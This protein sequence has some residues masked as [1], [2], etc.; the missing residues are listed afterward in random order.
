MHV[1]SSAWRDNPSFQFFSGGPNT[2]KP[3]GYR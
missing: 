1:A 3:D 2:V